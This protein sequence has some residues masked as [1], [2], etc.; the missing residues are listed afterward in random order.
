[1]LK[2]K[3]YKGPALEGLMASWYAK[4]TGKSRAEYEADARRLERE[5]KPGD[6]VLEIAPGPGYLAIALARL[7]PYRVTGLDISHSFVRIAR[8]NAAEAGVDVEFRFGDAASLPFA[9]NWFDLI[10]CRAAFKNFRNPVGA[11]KE[12]HRVLRPG[13]LAIIIDMRHDASNA[14]IDQQVIQMNFKGMEAF[15]TRAIFK[16]S[17]RRRAYSKAAFERMVAETHFG[18]AEIREE[19]L[20]F[21]V[22]LRKSS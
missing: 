19:A 9:A 4:N 18:V 22:R 12:M 2:V 16:Y 8:E 11:L 17:L 14:A 10:V 5:L 15:V 3:P 20:G 7:G 13:G 21:E 1:M 6:L